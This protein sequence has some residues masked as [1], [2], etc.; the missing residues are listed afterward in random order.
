[1]SA[2]AITPLQSR[3]YTF[4]FGARIDYDGGYGD[5]R[6][7][8]LLKISK[9]THELE[10]HFKMQVLCKNFLGLHVIWCT[11]FLTGSTTNVYE[12]QS[13]FSLFDCLI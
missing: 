6:W 5:S 7:C 2:F 9:F 1:M 3:Q 8:P 13:K 10:N 11:Q 4:G 12:R